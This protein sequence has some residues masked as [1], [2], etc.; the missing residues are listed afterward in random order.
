MPTALEETMM[1]LQTWNELTTW[2]K[3]H[4]QDVLSWSKCF[5]RTQRRLNGKV[6]IVVMVLSVGLYETKKVKKKTRLWNADLNHLCTW[7]DVRIA[8]EFS[9]L[10]NSHKMWQQKTV[11]V[12]L[13]VGCEHVVKMA[14]GQMDAETIRNSS[15]ARF[16]KVISVL[17]RQPGKNFQAN[18]KHST[19]SVAM[20]ITVEWR[21]AKQGFDLIHGIQRLVVTWN[22]QW[23]VHFTAKGIH[24]H[25][26]H[27]VQCHSH[28]NCDFQHQEK[29]NDS[30]PCLV[31][32]CQRTNANGLTVDNHIAVVFQCQQCIDFVVCILAV[33]EP[34][35]SSSTKKEEEEWM[36][37]SSILLFA[38]T[39]SA[40]RATLDS[41]HS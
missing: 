29:N 27:F 21:L 40:G 12:G 41:Y 11:F 5:Q 28:S 8:K 1:K 36:V 14:F 15:V 13:I 32:A 6:G 31:S 26:N 39:M 34:S 24:H 30:C 38:K 3:A 2:T 9:H 10:G 16:W 25:W 37:T 7:Y 20:T 23:W 18:E 33:N 22:F 19:W 4:K 35:W 17:R